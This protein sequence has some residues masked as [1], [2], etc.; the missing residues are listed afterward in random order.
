M[1]FFG[2]GTLGNPDRSQ[3]TA[4]GA[5]GQG[6]KNVNNAPIIGTALTR[7]EYAKKASDPGAPP[8][9]TAN[10]SAA[11]GSAKSAAEKQRKRAAAGSTLVSGSQT[12][13]PT[14]KLAPTTLLGF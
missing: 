8:S 9:V 13:S 7:E 10:T 6:R 4:G 11:V 3:W 14:A 5:S 1:A 2:N 12:S